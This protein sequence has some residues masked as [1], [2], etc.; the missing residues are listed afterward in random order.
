MAYTLPKIPARITA[1]TIAVAKAAGE[2]AKA[3]LEVDDL[4]AARA[5][6]IA[7]IAVLVEVLKPVTRA[8]WCAD[9]TE[10]ATGEVATVEIPGEDK[11][12]LIAP[13]APKPVAADGVLVAREA[14]SPEQVFWNAAVL[15]GWQ[16]FRPTYRRGTITALDTAAETASVTIT[17]DT[18]SAQNLA[19][20][21]TT[22][23]TNVPVQYM[24]CNAGA[25]EVGDKAVIKFMGGEWLQPKIVGFAENPRPCPYGVHLIFS[26]TGQSLQVTSGTAINARQYE[27]VSPATYYFVSL[28]SPTFTSAVLSKQVIA[29]VRLDTSGSAPDDPYPRHAQQDLVRYRLM[30]FFGGKLAMTRMSYTYSQTQFSLG[31][32]ESSSQEQKKVIYGGVD[33]VSGSLNYSGQSSGPGTSTQSYAYANYPNIFFS[34]WSVILGDVLDGTQNATSSPG[35]DAVVTGSIVPS[36]PWLS[37]SSRSSA[38]NQEQNPGYLISIASSTITVPSVPGQPVDRHDL[39]LFQY[40]INF[41][42]LIVR[43]CCKNIFYSWGTSSGASVDS[44][45]SIRIKRYD[46]ADPQYSYLSLPEL[47]GGHNCFFDEFVTSCRRAGT[48]NEFDLIV[49]GLDGMVLKKVTNRPGAPGV[50]GEGF[51][52]VTVPGLPAGARLV[53]A[54]RDEITCM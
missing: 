2:R 26:T 28:N 31:Y 53:G 10:D 27:L 54:L 50:D 51:T 21:L 44:L 6:L 43:A 20:N 4:T 8:A 42:G 33:L 40:S 12:L 7:R 48:G 45:T 9:F 39:N 47:A 15:P 34:G 41:E 16:K 17:A 37:L 35:N 18:S 30:S 38:A 29:D 32:S 22:H 49:Y 36:Y 23:L 24:T 46:R 19:I 5:G 14:Q 52:R 11:L 25:F 3:Q 1:A 13:G